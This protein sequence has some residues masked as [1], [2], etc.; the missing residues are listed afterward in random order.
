MNFGVEYSIYPL[1]DIDHADMATTMEQLELTPP[2]HIFADMGEQLRGYVYSAFR[3][4]LMRT[5]SQKDMLIES[6]SVSRVEEYRSALIERLRT[7]LGGIP[8]IG[9]PLLAETKS[10]L[11]LDG[12]RIEKVLFQSRPHVYVS[13]NLYVPD[14][15]TERTAAVLFVCG[16]AEAG[17]A[18]PEYQ[19]A[20]R[21]FAKAGMVA[22]AIDSFGLGE[23]ISYIN[24]QTRNRDVEWG[25]PEHD[26][27][28]AQI[29]MG[30]ESLARYFVHD[31]MRAVDYLSTR[32]EVDSS[33]IGVTGN[34]GGGTLTSLMMLLDSRIAAA[35]PGT[36]VT[37]MEAIL[38]AGLPQDAEQVWKNMLSEGIDHDD[39]L[40]AMA[41][42]PVMLLAAAYDYFPIEGTWY[43]YSSAKRFYELYGKADN[44]EIAVDAID[45]QYSP[46]LALAA[47]D[48]FSR[49]L[50]DRP[51][52]GATVERRVLSRSECN[53]TE[54]G[55]IRIS[56]PDARFAFEEQLDRVKNVISNRNLL[57][58]EERKT[59]AIAWLKERVLK[60]RKPCA[61][62]LR[63]FAHMH[64]DDMVAETLLYWSNKGV[65]S[66]AL[67][68]HC[69]SVNHC[70]GVSTVLAVWEGGTTNLQTHYDFIASHCRAGRQVVVLDLS[71]CGCMQPNRIMRSS[72][73]GYSGTTYTLNNDLIWLGDSLFALR[74][75]EIMRSLDMLVVELKIPAH[76]LFVYGEGYSAAY[77]A[78][79]C[80]LTDQAYAGCRLENYP[81]D[82]ESLV[83]SRVY[84]SYDIYNRI[85]PDSL[86]ELMLGK[87]SAEAFIEKMDADT[88]A[89]YG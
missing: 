29:L 81:P 58:T 36:L 59:R 23:R 45:H 52:D 21:L 65:F 80:L 53:C 11:Q 42:R 75:Y 68:F 48:F 76:K 49:Y 39:I 12:Y 47:A 66:N 3:E 82:M 69:P 61:F 7:C 62:G 88:A 86:N 43:T 56:L 70:D 26:H 28:G 27:V 79:A 14:G 85:L 25:C 64:V 67:L 20:C 34:S 8:P 13:G 9:E 84:N 40:I 77:V 16:H 31:A 72:S 71:G 73:T 50:L 19:H 2:C 37:S 4:A 74:S 24:S 54:S 10:I 35:A 63:R 38:A 1:W 32:P 89:Y 22:L 15:I 44:L 51:F 6:G 87:L 17:K 41:P 60:N 30:G 5:A 46:N 18:Y 78:A 33:R 83:H 57:P 55:Q